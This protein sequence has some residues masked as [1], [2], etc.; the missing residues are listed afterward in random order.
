MIEI[1]GSFG[2]GGGQILRYA[3]AISAI[4]GEKVRITNIRARRDN[5]GLQR[6]HL[7]AVNAITLVTRGY[8]EGNE[9]GS[10]ELIF[11][12]R[13]VYGGDYTFDIGTAGSVTLVLQSLLP[14]LAFADKPSR[15]RIR[16]GTD[17]PWSPTF[18]YFNN[19]F[20]EILRRLGYNVSL[21]LIR[22]GHYPRGGGEVLVEIK[23]CPRG[24]ESIQLAERG[25]LIEIRGNSHAVKL[26]RHVAERQAQAASERLRSLGIDVPIN[27]N[28]ESYPLD[29]D[30]HLGPGSGIALWALTEKSILGSD[31]LGARDRRAEEVGDRAARAL[32]EDLSTGA[33]LDRHM[34]DMIIPYLLFARGVSVVTGSM[35]TLHAY[36]VIEISKK[37]LPELRVEYD[38]S[39]N[40]P[41]KLI[42]RGVGGI[43]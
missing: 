27:I 42:V 32:F 39:L 7:T 14:V 38:G 13:G 35:L 41:F 17:V 18:D 23:N 10:T 6:Q 36:T 9:L 33:A 11:E 21:R 15:I 31:Y 12:P 24:F 30:P 28:I 5:P 40:K 22:R 29:K 3:L 16:G 26:P 43:I 34:S 1:D 37:I 19:V 25:K 4:I 8:V 2:E 20:I